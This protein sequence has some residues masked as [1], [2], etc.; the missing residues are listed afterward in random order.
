VLEV[1][2]VVGRVVAVVDA[3]WQWWTHCGHVKGVMLVVVMVL[4]AVVVVVCS[5]FTCQVLHVPNHGPNQLIL[6][7]HVKNEVDFVNRHLAALAESRQLP[8]RCDDTA[9]AA[10]LKARDTTSHPGR[11]FSFLFLSFLYY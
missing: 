11:F 9:A 4:V 8:R 5:S 7:H 2:R 3:L 1:G 6:I 10:A